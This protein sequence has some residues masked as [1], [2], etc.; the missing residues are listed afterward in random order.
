MNWKTSSDNPISGRFKAD[1]KAPDLSALS[2][3]HFLLK[4]IILLGV[5]ITLNFLC[6]KKLFL[7]KFIG[8][9]LVNL[10]V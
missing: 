7:W 4:L 2:L 1:A 5:V 3:M 6:V 8:L 10:T 9:M